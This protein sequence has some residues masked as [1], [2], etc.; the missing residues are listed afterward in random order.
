MIITRYGNATKKSPQWPE[1]DENMSAV[2]LCVFLNFDVL[3][4]RHAHYSGMWKNPKLDR[5]NKPSYSC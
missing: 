5:A 2:G 1:R 3:M 4:Q